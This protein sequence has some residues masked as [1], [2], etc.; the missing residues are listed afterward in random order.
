MTR[1]DRLLVRMRASKADW[2]TDE[3]LAVYR[4]R[5]FLV[6]SGGK[7]W[8]VRH[9]TYPEL[10]ATVRRSD[11]LPTGYIETLLEL[12]DELEEKERGRA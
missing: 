11:P 1:P 12:V 9:P 6:S 3:V 7:H 5:G 8:K 10:I 4:S 2:S